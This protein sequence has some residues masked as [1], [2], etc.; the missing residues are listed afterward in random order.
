MYNAAQMKASRVWSLRLSVYKFFSCSISF[1]V[2]VI[3][4]QFQIKHK[5]IVIQWIYL[6]CC[7]FVNRRIYSGF[8]LPKLFIVVQC[9][10]LRI[11]KSGFVFFSF[12]AYW[13]CFKF[14]LWTTCFVPVIVSSFSVLTLNSI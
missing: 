7:L 9:L 13:N 10:S 14:S 12:F 2:G 4:I 8:P 11:V 6:L 1:L 3:L 5:V